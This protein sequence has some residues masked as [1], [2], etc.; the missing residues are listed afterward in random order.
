[1]KVL[2]AGGAG[3]I[4]GHLVDSL[5]D[6]GH[7]VTVVDNLITGHLKNLAHHQ[8]DA[9]LS[10]HQVDVTRAGEV[11]CAEEADG[12]FDRIYH[13]ACPASPRGYGQHPLETLRVCS[14]GTWNL[15]HLAERSGARFLLT[16]TSEVYGEPEVHPQH[17][18]YWGHV[19]PVGPRSCYDEGKRFAESL[20]VSFAN[21]HGLDVRI[22]R[23]FNTYG[24]R[25]DVNDGRVIPNFCAQAMAGDPLT[26]YGDGTQTRSLCYVEDMV[27]GL[28]ALMEAPDLA[29]EIVNLGNPV[30][31]T[32]LEIAN[33]ILD[34]VQ[35]TSSIT[36]HPRPVDDPTRRRPDIRKAQRLLGWQPATAFREGLTLTLQ[37]RE[38]PPLEPS[39]I[40][41]A[42]DG[43]AVQARQPSNETR[44][45]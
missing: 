10:F 41:V 29:G 36:F 19:N 14:E 37:R 25:M 24:P 45:T 11:S 23:I 43:S 44:E 15:L 32:V 13:L 38:E 1:M 5:L 26:I 7:L 40:A 39:L 34:V 31:H 42:S 4:G 22:A 3:F 27:R 33:T 30:E 16:S 6:Q 28:Q 18:R 12:P 20:S 8:D 9:A 17:E 35:S 21:Q 2:V